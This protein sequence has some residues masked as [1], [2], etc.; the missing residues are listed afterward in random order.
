MPT[1]RSCLSTMPTFRTRGQFREFEAEIQFAVATSR[2]CS[3]GA[4]FTRFLRIIIRGRQNNHTSQYVA[5]V[6]CMR[7][8]ARVHA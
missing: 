6:T 2:W 7:R 5:T 3:K 8:H 1:S 4:R